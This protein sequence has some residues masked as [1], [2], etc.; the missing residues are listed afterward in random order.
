MKLTDLVKYLPLKQK[1]KV[2][3]L[4][5][6]FGIVEP[7]KKRVRAPKSVGTVSSDTVS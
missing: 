7:T 2:N 1:R 5:R 4:L 3:K 6:K